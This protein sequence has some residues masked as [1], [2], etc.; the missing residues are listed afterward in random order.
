MRQ[1]GIEKL[2][3][4]L[5]LNPLQP[6]QGNLEPFDSPSEQVQQTPEPSPTNVNS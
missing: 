1:M 3:F 5:Q 2:T 4:H 6:S